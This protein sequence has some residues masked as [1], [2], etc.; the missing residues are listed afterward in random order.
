MSDLISMDKMPAPYKDLLAKLQ[1]ETAFGGENFSTSR[2]ISLKQSTFRKIIN[3][4]EVQKLSEKHMDIVIVKA[5]PISRMY[6]ATAYVEG[7]SGPPTCWSADT[8]KGIPSPDV[9]AADRQSNSCHDCTQN[10]KGSG[11]GQG[12][13]CRFQQRLAVMLAEGISTRDIYTLTVP[14]ASIFKAVEHGMTM[15]SYARFLQ[16][17][18][19][20]VAALVTEISLDG[21]SSYPL[22]T[23]KP[24][25]PLEKNELEIV[26]EMQEHPDTIE[27]ITLK[28]TPAEEVEEDESFGRKVEA[29]ANS[30]GEDTDTP[31]IEFRDDK[32]TAEVEAKVEEPQKKTSK[33]TKIAEETPPQEALD[34][35]LDEWD[36]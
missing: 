7:D 29:P 3:G 8:S 36:D 26:V 16:A 19:T 31:A 1:P 24:A 34:E 21:D 17:H 11:Q 12:K 32:P 4:D 28:I 23:F 10:I 14:S 35:L 15:K 18:K 33:K 22:L 9:L 6:Y 27:A 13:A 20:P 5:A 30:N 25:R 2:R